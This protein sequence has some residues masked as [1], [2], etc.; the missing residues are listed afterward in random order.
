MVWPGYLTIAFNIVIIEFTTLLPYLC[1]LQQ[2]QIFA[3]IPKSVKESSN[4][5]RCLGISV[6][7]L[8][9]ALIMIGIVCHIWS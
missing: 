5:K 7:L 8:F 4:K 2:T 3:I 1:C 6:I 9:V